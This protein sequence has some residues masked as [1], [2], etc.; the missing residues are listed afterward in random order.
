MTDGPDE[1]TLA[2]LAFSHVLWE[3][4]NKIRMHERISDPKNKDAVEV[5]VDALRVELLRRLQ[6][7]RK[8]ARP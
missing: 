2:S 1:N 6:P 3:F 4:E 7:N 5:A 8:D